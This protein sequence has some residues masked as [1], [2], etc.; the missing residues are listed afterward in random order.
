[1]AGIVVEIQT[2]YGGA[3]HENLSK[4]HEIVKIA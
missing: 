4:I 1:M 3:R 2:L